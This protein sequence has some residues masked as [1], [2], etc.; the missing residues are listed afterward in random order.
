MSQIIEGRILEPREFKQPEQTMRL[1]EAAVLAHEQ[2]LDLRDAD[3]LRGGRP[4]PPD[5][6]VNMSFSVTTA[7]ERARQVVADIDPAHDRAMSTYCRVSA[8]PEIVEAAGGRA[9]TEWRRWLSEGANDDQL[10]EFLQWNYDAM[11]AM[12]NDPRVQMEIARQKADY[13]Q[14]LARGIQEGWLHPDANEAIGD[15]DEAHIYIGDPFDTYFRDVAGY[16]RY[17]ADW[18]VVAGERFNASWRSGV[19]SQLA[20]VGKHEINHLALGELPYWWLNEAATEHIARSLEEGQPDVLHPH[21]RHKEGVIYEKVRMLVDHLF[22]AG[23]TAI[24]T[25]EMTR[26][27]SS[28]TLSDRWDFVDTIN[29]SW[30]HAVPAHVGNSAVWLLDEFIEDREELL[31]AAGARAIVAR[32]RAVEEAYDTIRSNPHEIFNPERFEFGPITTLKLIFK[33]N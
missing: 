2:L 17:G 15:V 31:I 28:M 12:Q 25:E 7:L 27:Y 33:R 4:I 1:G 5:V 21:D 3:E 6:D 18:V 14:A 10:L 23:Q 29:E 9:S 16:Y 13:K 20:R 24:P 22:K 30:A 19:L 26:A 11:L 8:P 32:N